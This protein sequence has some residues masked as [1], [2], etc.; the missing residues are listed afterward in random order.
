VYICNPNNP[1]ASLTPRQDIEAFL[2]KLPAGVHVLIDEAYHHFATGAPEYVSFLDQ[3]VDDARVIVA[4]TFSKVY[5]LAGLRLGYAVA[6]EPAIEQLKR[7]KLWNG[8]NGVVS[9]CGVAALDD[10]AGMEALAAR[11][12][13][14][15]AEFVRQAE[16]RQ[17]ATVPSHANF[18]MLDTRRPVRN[19][20]RHFQSHNILVGRPF[21]QMETHARISLGKPAEMEAFWKVW[22]QMPAA[23]SQ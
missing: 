7:H 2:A 21:P 23:T 11:I 5:G 10:R 8:A 15:R 19:V 1:T 3:P 22:D 17:L 4:R 12:G 18:V 6:Q 20:I 9:G 13:R 16:K 14:D